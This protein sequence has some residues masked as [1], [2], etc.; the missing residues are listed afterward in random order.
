M[1]LN[2]NRLESP[3][4]LG[5]LAVHGA[6]TGELKGFLQ[7][8]WKAGAERGVET[9]VGYGL[10]FF[11]GPRVSVSAPFELRHFQFRPASSHER[12]TTGSGLY[13]AEGITDSVRTTDVLLMLRADDGHVLAQHLAWVCQRGREGSLEVTIVSKSEREPSGR[14]V[15]GF[16]EGISKIQKVRD[17]E[18]V[19]TCQPLRRDS[20]MNGGTYCVYIRF[21]FDLPAWNAVAPALQEQ[22]VGRQKASGGLLHVPGSHVSIMRQR[23]YPPSDRRSLQ[24]LREAWNFR[25]QGGRFSDGLDFFS[26]QESPFRTFEIL[27][28]GRWLGGRAFGGP[29]GIVNKDIIRVLA[30]GVFALPPLVNAS[31][32]PGASNFA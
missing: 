7:K 22:C 14:N 3:A 29:A 24:I 5:V 26:Y 20:W 19:V 28:S 13:Y 4:A 30:A 11:Q 31:I 23:K 17:R 32:L 10:S 6:A 27:S 9:L 16:H 21:G 12:L 15:L 18:S 8:A 2:L 1:Q 25:D